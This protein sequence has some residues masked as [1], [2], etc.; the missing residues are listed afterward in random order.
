[1]RGIADPAAQ[2]STGNPT[3]LRDE[4]ILMLDAAMAA[5]RQARTALKSSVSATPNP[6]DPYLGLARTERFRNANGVT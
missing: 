2:R 1:M 6:V 4:L 3:W 5:T